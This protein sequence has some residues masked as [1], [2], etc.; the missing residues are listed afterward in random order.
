[1]TR[2][3][4]LVW[5]LYRGIV[6]KQWLSIYVRDEDVSIWRCRDGTCVSIGDGVNGLRASLEAHSVWPVFVF[7]EARQEFF[8]PTA[9]LFS[10]LIHAVRNHVKRSASNTDEVMLWSHRGALSLSTSSTVLQ[11]VVRTLREKQCGY[12]VYSFSALY[13]RFCQKHFKPKAE[14]IFDVHIQQSSWWGGVWKRGR[15]SYA[16]KGPYTPDDGMQLCHDIRETVHHAAPILGH[17]RPEVQ[18]R[19]EPSGLDPSSIDLDIQVSQPTTTPLDVIAW[20]LP[21]RLWFMMGG[22]TISP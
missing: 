15:L 14:H 8:N 13:W 10:F 22:K 5:G 16:R 21:R 6:Q 12:S 4:N 2:L 7:F 3:Y 18:I 9:N 19:G 1:M 20:G 11:D 17:T